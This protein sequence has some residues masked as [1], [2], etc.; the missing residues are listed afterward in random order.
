MKEGRGIGKRKRK[1]KRK[2]ISK[3]TRMLFTHEEIYNL[4]LE[5]EINNLILEEEEKL[6]KDID[7]LKIELGIRLRYTDKE[8]RE[9][10]ITY[11][12]AHLIYGIE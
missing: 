4:L 10:Y 8:I 5:E 2:K 9:L 7:K 3:L 12:F 6:E 1:R 11:F